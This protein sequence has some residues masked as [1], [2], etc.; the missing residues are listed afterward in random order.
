MN[1]RSHTSYTQLQ[2][3][4]FSSF[5]LHQPTN[6]PFSAVPDPMNWTGGRLSRHSSKNNGS[7]NSRQKH[8][9]AKAQSYQS[10]K[11][12]PLR[13]LTYDKFE[14]DLQENYQ[15]EAIRVRS[16][17]YSHH[18]IGI[19]LQALHHQR[20]SS[21][22]ENMMDRPHSDIKMDSL[23][24]GRSRSRSTQRFEPGPFRQSTTEEDRVSYNDTY[25]TSPKPR[26]L[27]RPSRH[28]GLSLPS[29]D[30]EHGM[31]IELNLTKRKKLLHKVDWAGVSLQRPIQLNF[32]SPRRKQ[33]IG[34]RRKIKDGH[35]A[36]FN[37]NLQPTVPLQNTGRRLHSYSE[38][39]EHRQA[40]ETQYGNSDVRISIGGRIFPPG[41]SPSIAPSERS[42]AI[43]MPSFEPM[44]LD[45]VEANI[46]NEQRK[47]QVFSSPIVSMHHPRPT[48]S[49][50]SSLI[51]ISN[52]SGSESGDSTTAQLGH[53]KKIIPSSQVLD[54]HMW[55]EWAADHEA[56]YKKKELSTAIKNAPQSPGDSANSEFPVDKQHE[57]SGLDIKTILQRVNMNS[58]MAR[59]QAQPRN[60]SYNEVYESV[61]TDIEGP[62]DQS[63]GCDGIVGDN[64]GEDK[65]NN[66][67]DGLLSESFSENDEQ[68]DYKIH[69]D[70]LPTD[71]AQTQ[72]QFER[73][74]SKYIDLDNLWKAFVFGSSPSCGD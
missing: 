70:E 55:E 51:H 54:N 8:H 47:L 67:Y 12:S 50:V 32:T 72:P 65:T 38:S 10:R 6:L 41:I 61:G 19:G 37:S 2:K 5:I 7:L 4:P 16:R 17:R 48:S 22:V 27:R 44:L 49:R 31:E 46:S 59:G 28:R 13:R 68:M 71:A 52:S 74:R 35:G 11:R 63:E 3:H 26:E 39:L 18:E 73:Q 42:S 21:L 23:S 20:L 56:T 14:T 9:F 43:Q 29:S 57:S 62:F 64:I 30:R 66:Y 60:N 1:T 36:L 33:K 45:E 58:S 24:Y 69:Q 40:N 15:E 25:G 53:S 34:R